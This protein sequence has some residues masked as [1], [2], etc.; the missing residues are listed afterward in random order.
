MSLDDIYIPTAVISNLE[1]V[2]LELFSLFEI[3]SFNGIQVATAWQTLSTT[4]LD[5]KD[6]RILKTAPETVVLLFECTSCDQNG[7]VI[8][9]N[10]SYTLSSRASYTVRY[11]REP[12][13]PG[14]DAH[15][16]K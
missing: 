5:A 15:D 9:F 13:I 12:R 2:N 7:R 10:R 4:R 14:R 8:E 1:N 6:A 11:Q 3:L 16:S